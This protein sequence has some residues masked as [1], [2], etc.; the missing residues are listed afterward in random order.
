MQKIKIEL[1]ADGIM[2][3]KASDGAAGFDCYARCDCPVTN[4]PMVIPLGFKIELPE[5][6]CAKILP[7]SSTGLK[8]S[9]RMA[10][11]VGIIDCD[12]RGEVGFIAEAKFNSYNFVRKGDRIAQMLIERVEDVELVKAYGLSETKRGTGGFGSTGK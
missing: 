10:N 8:T 1:V 6:Y 12:Y 4:N 11:S 3:E 2:P 7:R 9:I 5:G